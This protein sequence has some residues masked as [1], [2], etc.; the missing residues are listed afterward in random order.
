VKTLVTGGSGFIA[1]HLIRH[2]LNKGEST[3]AWSR[4]D[5]PSDIDASDDL[6]W[7]RLDLTDVDAV[8]QAMEAAQPD[9]VFHLSAQSLPRVS[10]E[11]PTGTFD[12]NVIGTIN[13]LSALQRHAPKAR[14]VLASSSSVYASHDPHRPIQEDDPLGGTSLYAISKRAQEMTARLWG[15]H[16]TMPVIIVRPFFV[17]GPGKTGDVCSDLARR[18]VR[19]QR[20]G[21]RRISVGNLS[22]VRDFVGIEDAV[23]AFTLLAERGTPDQVYNLCRGSGWAIQDVL[24]YYLASATQQCEIHVDPNLLRPVDEPVRIGDPGKL[25]ALGWEPVVSMEKVLDGILDYW[26]DV[27]DE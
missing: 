6:V 21:E 10:W 26:R 18:V 23:A 5:K 13:V 15:R 12:A 25:R 1:R 11:N 4:Q 27:H 9:R 2:T 19:A 20:A 16:Y 24:A 3:V 14:L 8:E 7:H 22:A 17:I